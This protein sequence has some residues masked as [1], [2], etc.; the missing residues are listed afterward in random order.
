MKAT[1]VLDEQILQ[2]QNEI[3]AEAEK[4]YENGTSLF[5]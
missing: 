2:M 5:Y 4:Q 3:V 1:I